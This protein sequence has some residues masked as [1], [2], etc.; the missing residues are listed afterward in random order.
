MGEILLYCV[1]MTHHL[2]WNMTYLGHL[3]GYAIR[4]DL[5]QIF[6][7]TFWGQNAYL[8]FDASRREEYDDVSLFYLHQ[9]KCYLQKH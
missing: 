1:V 2:I 4:P 6:K 8:C 9:F 7:L 3:P 5:G